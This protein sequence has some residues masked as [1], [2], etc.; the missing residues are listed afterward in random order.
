MFTYMVIFVLRAFELS[1][2]LYCFVNI[3]GII[4]WS[5]LCMR[6]LSVLHEG[7]EHNS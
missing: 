6:E 4:P 2:I 7:L 1:D 3:C 5:N